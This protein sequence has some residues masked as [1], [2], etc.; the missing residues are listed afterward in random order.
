LGSNVGLWGVGQTKPTGKNN[1]ENFQPRGVEITDSPNRKRGGQKQRPFN[2]KEV[3][4]NGEF[5]AL[6]E[7]G[8]TSE[9]KKRQLKQ[10]TDDP[11][12]S[13]TG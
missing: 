13:K 1:T 3:Q 7:I 10:R 2:E 8:A 9:G 4:K 5:A 11:A 12:L 6:G